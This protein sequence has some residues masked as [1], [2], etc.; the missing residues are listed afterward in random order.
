MKS[1]RKRERERGFQDRLDDKESAEK[2]RESENGGNV[3]R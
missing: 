3:E 2:A 1:K